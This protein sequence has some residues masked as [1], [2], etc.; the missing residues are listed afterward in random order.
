MNYEEVGMRNTE[1]IAGTKMQEEAIIGR[2]LSLT[3]GKPQVKSK[4]KSRDTD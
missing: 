2:T 3:L 4:K 1:V